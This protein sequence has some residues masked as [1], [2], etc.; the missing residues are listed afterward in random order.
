VGIFGMN[1]PAYFALD[2]LL[3]TRLKGDLN[4]DG[5]V[6]ALDLPAMLR[7]LSDLQKYEADSQFGVEELSEVA[8]INGDGVVTNADIQS[9]IG[10]LASGGNGSLSSVP[11]P[12]SLI[13]AAIGG[14]ALVFRIAMRPR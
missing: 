14:V 1:T 6:D 13:L 2:D 9:L 4:L 12:G 11:E 8:D 10:L 5:N 7:A 3:L